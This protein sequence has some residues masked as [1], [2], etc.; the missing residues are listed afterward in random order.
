SDRRQI[1]SCGDANFDVLLNERLE[2]CQ[3][4]FG[5]GIQIKGFASKV[6]FTAQGKELFGDS[7]RATG[8][9]RDLPQFLDRFGIGLLSEEASR[10]FVERN[11]AGRKLLHEAARHVSQR[12][13]LE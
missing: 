12:L 5:G 13:E 9:G 8:D 2:G 6:L 10:A 11:E 1:G 3:T 4:L 7:G